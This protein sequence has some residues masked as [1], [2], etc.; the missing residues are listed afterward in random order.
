[1]QVSFVCTGN[2]Q[3]SKDRI[4]FL[5]MYNWYAKFRI[6]DVTND[7]HFKNWRDICNRELI[8]KKTAMQG[9]KPS[10]EETRSTFF[11]GM[12]GYMIFTLLI[13]QTKLLVPLNYNMVLGIL[14]I[15]NYASSLVIFLWTLLLFFVP[16]KMHSWISVVGSMARQKMYYWAAWM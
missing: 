15:S 13:N 8:L 10:I 4:C 12:N 2:F 9:R 5:Y 14:R 7:N 1:M 6:E 11:L 3:G 16:G